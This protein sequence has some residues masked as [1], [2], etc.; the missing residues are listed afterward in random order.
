[1]SDKIFALRSNQD[2]FLVVD[3]KPFRCECGANV[4]RQ[5]VYP[6][7]PPG[8]VTFQCNGCFEI[9]CGEVEEKNE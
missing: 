9:Y 4:F 8:H 3:G 5:V 7:D 2:S 1:M 6:G